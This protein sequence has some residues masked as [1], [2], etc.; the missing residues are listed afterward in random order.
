MIFQLEVEVPLA[1]TVA[2]LTVGK[3]HRRM[4]LHVACVG[5]RD[6]VG[7]QCPPEPRKVVCH[8][9]RRSVH[10]VGV[11][12]NALPKATSSPCRSR[13]Q[14]ARGLLRFRVG[15]ATADSEDLEI[16]LP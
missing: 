15:S 4:P 12:D 7:R 6:R 2:P 9:L 11:G 5:M 3:H 14:N 8:K 16:V 10:V 13:S 1:V